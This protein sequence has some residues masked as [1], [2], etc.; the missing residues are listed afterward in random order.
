MPSTA[1]KE[2]SEINK[3]CG[4]RIRNIRKSK[5]ITAERLSEMSGV[6]KG[7]IFKVEKGLKSPTISILEKLANALEVHI[8]IFFTFE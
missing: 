1:S 8:V 4:A 7:Y 5:G 2:Q 6:S 3:K